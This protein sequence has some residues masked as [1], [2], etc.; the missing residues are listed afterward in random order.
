ME[1][2]S[3]ITI[4]LIC[5]TENT[6]SLS[7]SLLCQ[8]AEL[9][10]H[11]TVGIILWQLC[12]FT[13]LLIVHGSTNFV[14]IIKNKNKTWIFCGLT[15]RLIPTTLVIRSNSNKFDW[16]STPEMQWMLTLGPYLFPFVESATRQHALVWDPLACVVWY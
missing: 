13:H 10:Q 4:H 16:V 6:V 3:V 9:R 5:Y 7:L 1:A 12:F 8:S 2:F 15:V 14:S 11:K